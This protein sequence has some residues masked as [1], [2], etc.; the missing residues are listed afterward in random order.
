M[1]ATIQWNF[2]FDIK[3]DYF[4]QWKIYFLRDVFNRPSIVKHTNQAY[5]IR[6]FLWQ[7]FKLTNFDFIKNTR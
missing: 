6:L 7:D 4:F 1:M 2:L 5:Y 3:Q